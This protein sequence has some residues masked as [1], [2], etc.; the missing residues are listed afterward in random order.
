[1]T[2]ERRWF[3]W[4]LRVALLLAAAPGVWYAGAMRK[5]AIPETRPGAGS[6]RVSGDSPVAGPQ[7]T[8]LEVRP[9]VG[10]LAPD[11]ALPDLKGR[12]VR[13]SD[14]RGR[15]AVF[16]NFWATWCP[17]CRAEMPTMEQAYR[18]YR[19]RGLQIL[20]IS[21]DTEP[22]ET[23]QAFGVEP[24]L[25][26]PARPRHDGHSGVPDCRNPRLR[27]DRPAGCDPGGGGRLPGLVQTR[28]PEEARAAP[29]IAV[30][31]HLLLG[32][33]IVI[34]AL[35][36]VLPRATALPIA[37]VLGIV[38]A[39]VGYQGARA[40]RRPAITGPD[41]VVGRV[42]E[43]ASDPAPEGLVRIGAELWAA[44]AGVRVPKGGSAAVV[45]VRG[46]KLAVQ[47]AQKAEV[48][49]EAR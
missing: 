3:A 30:R 18:T 33:P 20:A 41:A 37:L 8:V 17:P 16:V 31:C 46:V 1:M 23:V 21:I 27:A 4:K 10:Y 40:L 19:A 35:L 6:S 36:L 11:F 34:A 24:D 9:Q 29:R 38:T 12:T 48:T 44:A 26:G 2:P 42:R 22:K 13:L 5:S 14:F 49:H 43:A 25:P 28:V 45:G 39:V 32:V 15:Q 7:G 47:P